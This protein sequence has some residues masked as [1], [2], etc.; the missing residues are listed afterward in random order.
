MVHLT[1]KVLGS[2]ISAIKNLRELKGSTLQEILQYISSIYNIS[3]AVARRQVYINYIL[4][5]RSLN[6]TI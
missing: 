6:E 1:A 5:L 3:S 2:V 4:F